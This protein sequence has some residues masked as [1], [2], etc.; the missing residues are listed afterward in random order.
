MYWSRVGGRWLWLPHRRCAVL[1]VTREAAEMRASEWGGVALAVEVLDGRRT[2]ENENC[3]VEV[4][5][6]KAAK[7]R[8]FF[9]RFDGVSVGVWGL[10]GLCRKAG[11]SFCG[12]R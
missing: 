10:L 4:L 1:F 7:Q 9:V 3:G 6:E 2:A 5:N 11:S 12:R 8:P